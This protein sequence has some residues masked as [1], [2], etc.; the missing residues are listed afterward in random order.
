MSKDIDNLIVSV[1]KSLKDFAE[2]KLSRNDALE[3]YN[4]LCSKYNNTANK[5]K[6][7][8]SLNQ[9]E[10]LCYYNNIE[11]YS[12]LSGIYNL[13]KN[14]IYYMAYYGDNNLNSNTMKSIA[15]NTETISDNEIF[16]I[17]SSDENFPYNIF[18]FPV[19]SDESAKT[20]F[21]SVSSSVFFSEDKF[22]FLA[23]LIKYVFSVLLDKTEQFKDNYFNNVSKEVENYLNNN[24]DDVHS[25]RVTLFVFNML[26]KIFNH[27]GIHSLLEVSDE[28]LK[29][30][31]ENY[32]HN[33]RCLA[34]SI[35]DYIVLEKINKKDT[36]KTSAQKL[37]F[38]YKSVNIP[39]HSIRLKIDTKEYIYS[40]W[41]KLLTFEN[42]LATGDIL[43]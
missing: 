22:I 32:R 9:V 41:D 36:F 14:N 25:V 23:K 29:I 6:K 43:K 26:E 5:Y 18:V 17:P 2:G 38:L 8:E 20:V 37:E 4:N 13:S 24:I 27:T 28:V 7:N 30:L 34:L 12:L 15:D 16:Q 39:Y 10:G 3:E 11:N 35:R 42:Y 33:S 31:S 19:F 21:A 40:L 1:S